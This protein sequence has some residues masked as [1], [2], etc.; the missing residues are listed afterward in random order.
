MIGI[1]KITSPSGK[2]YIGQS[3]T[4][5]KR[6]SYYN[7]LACKGQT[8]LYNSLIA[9][10]FA[11]HTFTVMEECPIEELAKRERFW[12]DFY[13]VTGKGGLN[14]I[15]TTTDELEI[16]YSQETRRN[17]SVK[18]SA[19]YQTEEGRII[20]AKQINSTDYAARSKKYYKGI[21]QYKLNG[22]YIAEWPSVKEAGETLKISRSNISSC[23]TGKLTSSGGF[24][25]KY[26]EKEL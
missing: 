2:V 8:R 5:E 3:K 13:N 15:K 25:W 18:K 22:E 24:V 10:G 11:A 19:L 17:M 9:Y 23:L 12:Q 21:L 6:R 26:K 4:L 7:R 14:C 16:V 1:Y 20:R